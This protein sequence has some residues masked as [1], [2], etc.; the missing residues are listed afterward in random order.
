[1]NSKAGR[2]NCNKLQNV[3]KDS[4]KKNKIMRNQKLVRKSTAQRRKK[5]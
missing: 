4:T 1:M 5:K 2:E 3:V